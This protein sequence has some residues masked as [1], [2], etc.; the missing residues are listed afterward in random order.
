MPTYQTKWGNHELRDLSTTVNHC[1]AMGGLSPNL[2]SMYIKKILIYVGN[3]SGNLRVGV[4]TGGSLTTGPAGATLRWDAGT[5]GTTQ[6]GWIEIEHGSSVYWPAN[7]ATWVVWKGNNGTRQ[8][9]YSDNVVDCGDYQSARGRW[10]SVSMS[11]DEYVAYPSTW[12]ADGGSFASYWYNIY[13]V[14]QRSGTNAYNTRGWQSG[15]NLYSF[16]LRTMDSAIWYNQ[17]PRYEST[18]HAYPGS[19]SVQDWQSGDTFWLTD[20]NQMDSRV[21]ENQYPR[22]TYQAMASRG[23]DYTLQ[24]WESG[25]TVPA[26]KVRAMDSTIW[27]NQHPRYQDIFFED[28]TCDVCRVPF[29]FGDILVLAVTKI[30]A[31]GIWAR[32]VHLKCIPI[33]IGGKTVWVSP[34]PR[35]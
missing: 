15:E 31:D 17:F 30:Q 7:T 29:N 10:N 27:E 1:R 11:T 22:F 2:S 33:S 6:S 20:A 3:L 19:Y 35:I 28:H 4:Y 32:P 21:W 26:A 34:G 5:I 12:P 14:F 9:S 16:D 13:I 18:S 8:V 25:D 23:T 24:D